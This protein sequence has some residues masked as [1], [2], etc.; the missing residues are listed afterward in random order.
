MFC[1]LN[2]QVYFT[3]FAAR[4]QSRIAE[5]VKLFCEPVRSDR[6]LT[7]S[8]PGG[9]IVAQVSVAQQDRAFAS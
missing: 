6:F 9:I 7:A 4:R 3:A 1:K 5:F 2:L 8:V